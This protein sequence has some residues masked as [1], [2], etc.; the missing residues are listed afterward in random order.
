MIGLFTPKYVFDTGPIIELK[1]Y[2]SDVFITLWE[3]LDI[4][5]QQDILSSSEVYRELDKRDDDAKAIGD[6]YK[7]IFKKPELEELSYVKKILENHTELIKVK[8]ILGG[9]PVADPFVIAQAICN[10]SILVT[11][12]LYKPNSHNIPNI[13]KE[14]EI[15][16]INLKGLFIKEGWTF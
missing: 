7:F 3:N 14:Y 8:N 6:K 12:E 16:C 4:L 9:M 1:S 2:Y 15:E 13:C 5:F 11:S 10:R